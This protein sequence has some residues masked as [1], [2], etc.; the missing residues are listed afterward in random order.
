MKDS[1]DPNP[2]DVRNLQIL[3]SI[4]IFYNKN[5]GSI[6]VQFATTENVVKHET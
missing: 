1:E 5:L 6:N 3:H 4:Y 2:L